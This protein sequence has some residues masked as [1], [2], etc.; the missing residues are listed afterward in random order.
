MDNKK[1]LG[2]EV[3]LNG[4]TQNKQISTSIYIIRHTALSRAAGWKDNFG[5]RLCKFYF[6]HVGDR[7]RAI[8][9][10]WC[11]II[12][13]NILLN[14]N[15][16]TLCVRVQHNLMMRVGLKICLLK[17]FKIYCHPSHSS[18]SEKFN[19]SLPENF[20]DPRTQINGDISAVTKTKWWLWWLLVESL[21][22]II[23]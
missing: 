18:S 3:T 11:Q 23:L 2:V 1:I 21:S 6:S 12:S 20:C 9:T 15:F 8:I 22:K 10:I 19:F 7:R 17:D 5:K 14:F 13:H 4:K 16:V